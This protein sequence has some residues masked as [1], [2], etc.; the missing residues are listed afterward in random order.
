MDQK[1]LINEQGELIDYNAEDEWNALCSTRMQNGKNDYELDE[2][3]NFTLLL[4]DKNNDDWMRV[5]DNYLKIFTT[6]RFTGGKNKQKKNR[7]IKIKTQKKKT[8]KKKTQK[9]R[10]TKKN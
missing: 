8:K 1:Y 10:K 2:D 5:L 4:N 6:T 9:R 7:K 3:G